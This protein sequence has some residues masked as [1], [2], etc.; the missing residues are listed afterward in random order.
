LSQTAAIT[1]VLRKQIKKQFCK[2]GVLKSTYTRERGYIYV[3][4]RGI[5]KD[6][7]ALTAR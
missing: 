7:I 6:K 5:E 1:V 3:N 2:L 4:D